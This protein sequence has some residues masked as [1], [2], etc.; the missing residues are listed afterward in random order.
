MYRLFFPLIIITF[1]AGC[2]RP[3]ANVEFKSEQVTRVIEQMTDIMVHDVTNPPL[4]ARFFSYATLAGYEIVSQNDR[5]F[6]SMHGRLNQYPKIHIPDT[7][8]GYSYQLSAIL[9]MMETAARLQPSGHIMKENENKFI[10]SCI[11]AGIDEAQ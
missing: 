8:S 11:N 1:I 10:D 6:K 9:A 4:A 5:G 7:I 3:A 2:S